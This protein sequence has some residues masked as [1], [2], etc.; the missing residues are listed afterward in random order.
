MVP[1]PVMVHQTVLD[2]YQVNYGSSDL[3]SEFLDLYYQCEER[4]KTIM[5]TRNSVVLQT[6]EGMLGLWGA[7][8]SVLKTGDPVLAISTGV[9]GD[10][11]GDMAEMV[12]ARVQ[13][14]SLGYDETISDIDALEKAIREFRPKMITAVHCETPS[15]TLNPLEDLGRLKHDLGVPLLYVDAVSS[16]GGTPVATDAWHIDLC[17]GGSQKCLSSLSDMTFLSVSDEAW[18]TIEDVGYNGYDALIPFRTAQKNHYFPYTPNWH[19]IAGL[20][21]GADVILKEGLESCFDR[22]ERVASWCRNRLAEI[23]LSLF[24][25]PGAVSSPTVTAVYVPENMSWDEFDHLLRDKGLVVGG[26]YGPLAEKVFRL[27][28]MGTQAEHHLVEQAL[29][30]IESVIGKL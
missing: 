5:A 8:K 18:E 1:G 10:G 28:H 15:G 21:A 9:F 29:G 23:G 24:P 20:S 30:I 16:I 26:S 7:L 13:K 6:G 4:L 14:V 22:H 19:G 11:I 27:G 3:E 2:A 25:L 12:G 17:L